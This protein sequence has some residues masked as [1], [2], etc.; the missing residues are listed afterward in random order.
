MTGR[1]LRTLRTAVRFI[2][3]GAAGLAMAACGF[4]LQGGAT[5]DE[6]LS[7]VYLQVPDASTP[8]ARAL[9]RSMEAARVPLD[10]LRKS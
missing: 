5:Y 4:Q 2:A 6:E 9:R 10:R 1:P 8:L 3:L 7:A